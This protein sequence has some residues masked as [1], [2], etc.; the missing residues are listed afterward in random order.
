MS[1]FPFTA[2]M[3]QL[4]KFGK[5]GILNATLLL[6]IVTTKREDI[7]DMDAVADSMANDDREVTE[8]KMT[9]FLSK[10]NSLYDPRMRGGLEDAMRY[11]YL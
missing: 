9:A 4:K 10:N 2:L 8:G 3:R 5:F 7:P 6:P 11:G 1:Q